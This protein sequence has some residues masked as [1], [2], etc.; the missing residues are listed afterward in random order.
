M[1]VG[2]GSRPAASAAAI[3]SMAVRGV[4]DDPGASMAV[5][6]ALGTD[7]PDGLPTAARRP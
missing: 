2:V 1:G 4:S 7:P 6:G 3:H 5:A